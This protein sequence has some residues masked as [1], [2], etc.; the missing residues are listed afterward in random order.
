MKNRVRSA[1]ASG[2]SR[3]AVA[4]HGSRIA[5]AVGL[6]CCSFSVAQA[7]I[8]SVFPSWSP[9]YLDVHHI[10]TGK[11]SAAFF[12]L[13]DGTTMLFDAGATARPGPRVA[14]PRPDGSRRPGE[15]IARYIRHM[16]AGVRDPALD[17][18][19]LSHFHDDHIGGITEHTPPS[20]SGAYRL[21]G[22]TDVAEAI[23]VRTVLDRAWPGYDW[24]VELT[25]DYVQNYR[26]FLQW[27]IANRGLNVERFAPGR[28]DQVVLLRQPDGYPGFEIRNIAANGEVWTGVHTNT[29]R[30][31]PPLE[32][33][34]P[35]DWPSENMCSI[36]LRLSYGAF[37]YYTGGDL[38][39]I[40]PAGS[41]AWRD[42]ET[43]VAQAVG[44]V[45]V[46]VVNHHGVADA[47]SAYFLSVL[48]PQVHILESWAPTHPTP[49]ALSRLLSTRLYPDRREI[50][51][52]NTME[53]TNT[54]IGP[55][56]DRLASRQ[57]HVVVRVEPGGEQYRVFVLDDSSESYAVTGV[58]G[59]YQSR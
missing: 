25:A 16:L 27:Q 51:A 39:G 28:N 5:L 33:L 15:W 1:R 56:M 58:H 17:Y 52:T 40:P 32:V 3:V 35:A 38:V 43:P 44:P 7:Q 45:E 26:R 37:D 41:P 31:I 30:H 19:I 11:G 24:P 14:D 9:G 42:L 22:I 10:S 29:R 8:G 55:P 50:F 57:G 53:V 18:V 46:H 48:R 36:V 34:E 12:V 47:A 4:G 54:Y 13:P 59:P 23:P 49:S 21:T 6:L 2:K 20:A